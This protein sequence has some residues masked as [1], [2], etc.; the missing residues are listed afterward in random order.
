MTS[1]VRAQEKTACVLLV[2]DDPDWRMLVCD[3]IHQERPGCDVCEAAD[4]AEALRLLRCGPEAGARRPDLI[5]LDIEMP[6]L[7]GCQVLEAIKSDPELRDIP[8][9]IMT[10]L[11]DEN[12]RLEAERIG[13]DSFAVKSTDFC[14]V[15]Q[16]VSQT[17]C[18]W[19]W[20]QRRRDAIAG[21]QEGQP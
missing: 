2:D 4:G 6:G 7:S 18:R 16:T 8:V 15:V 11:E 14:T 9:A 1:R 17:M 19:L 12:V 5:F 3:V 10:G 21:E 13:A 20:S